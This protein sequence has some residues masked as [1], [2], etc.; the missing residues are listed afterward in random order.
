M[1]DVFS[2][3][4]DPLFWLHHCQMDRIWALWQSLDPRRQNDMA[5]T[6]SRPTTLDTM[7]WM[8]FNAPDVP[9]RAVMDTVNQGG[10]GILCYKYDVGAEEYLDEL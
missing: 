10:D 9:I 8:G 5:G 2:S 7:L 4:N 1:M 3:P 6:S